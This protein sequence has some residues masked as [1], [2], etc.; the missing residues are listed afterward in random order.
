LVYIDGRTLSVYTDR[1][2]DEYCQSVYTDIIGDGIIFVG[3]N[4]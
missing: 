1:I 3:K 2:A 4:Y